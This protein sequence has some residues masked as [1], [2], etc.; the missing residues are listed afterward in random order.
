MVARDAVALAP[1]PTLMLL[2]LLRRL[3]FPTNWQ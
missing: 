2:W 3:L 1:M